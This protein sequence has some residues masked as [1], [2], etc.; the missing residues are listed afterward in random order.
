MSKLLF[1]ILIQRKRKERQERETIH[2]RIREDRGSEQGASRNLDLAADR[3]RYVGGVYDMIMIY[4]EQSLELIFC[5]IASTVR[6][7]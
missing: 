7:S 4:K 3:D 1:R 2:R 5:F 6:C